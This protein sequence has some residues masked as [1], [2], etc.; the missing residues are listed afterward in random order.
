M[1]KLSSGIIRIALYVLL[2]APLLLF[3]V[4]AFSTRWFFPDPFPA[5]WT[6][7]TFQRA[8]NDSRTFSSVTQG[9]WIAALVSLFSLVIGFPAARVLGLRNFRGRQLAWLLLFLPTV[10]PPLAIGMGLNVLFLRIGL[11]GSILGVALAHIV[12]TL[13]Y[14]VFTL[15]SAFARFD[16]NYEYQALA[17]GANPWRIFFTI[18]LRLMMPSLVVAALF[19][20]LISWSQYLLTLL[21]GGGQVITLPVL[22]FSAASG[23]NPATIATLSLLFVAP[24]ILVIAITARQLNERGN[25][26][27]KQ[28]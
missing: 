4:Y 5:E 2:I 15:S 9:L 8:L 22:L 1:K 27:R 25:E 26:I 17:L 19:A 24:P 6:T 23:G 10:I 13:P 7:T 14:T 28:F 12:P 20:F 18:T 3:L 21:I 16:E 11:A